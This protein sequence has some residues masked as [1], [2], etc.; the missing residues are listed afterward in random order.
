MH[1]LTYKI[2]YDCKNCSMSYWLYEN[3]HNCETHNIL[4]DYECDNCYQMDVLLNL[5]RINNE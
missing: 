5:E 2:K 4:N 3:E 1:K